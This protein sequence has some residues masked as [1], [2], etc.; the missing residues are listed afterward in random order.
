MATIT[1][2]F[3][4]KK[5]NRRD[6]KTKKVST[7]NGVKPELMKGQSKNQENYLTHGDLEL[8]LLDFDLR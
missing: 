3:P 4:A 1:Q 8:D 7:T 6:V 2:H 5:T